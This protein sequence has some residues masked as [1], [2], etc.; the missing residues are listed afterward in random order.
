MEAGTPGPA[1]PVLPR[2]ARLAQWCFGTAAALALTVLG[3]W[4]A[5]RPQAFTFGATF[6]AMAPTTALAIT[7][8][9]AL[10]SAV[11]R[12]PGPQRRAVLVRALLGFVVAVGVL[13]LA[14]P[15]RLEVLVDSWLGG[16]DVSAARPF[17][18]R[19]SRYTAALLALIAVAAWLSLR[20]TALASRAA[21]R[22]GGAATLI[23]LLI[24]EGYLLGGAPLYGGH[25]MPIALLTTVAL[26]LLGSGVVLSTP[27]VPA[28]ESAFDR[29]FGVPAGFGIV[30]G[31]TALLVAGG[32][33]AWWEAQRRSHDAQTR[34]ALTAV[35]RG[36]ASQID[37]WL[38][39]HLS[40]GRA[41]EAIRWSRSVLGTPLDA[42]VVQWLQAIVA[43]EGYAEG[44]I[45][46]PAGVVLASVGALD[47]R[48]A[49]EFLQHTTRSS[50]QGAVT[51]TDIHRHGERV[52]LEL[53]TPLRTIDDTLPSAWLFLS[54]DAQ[55]TL[56][57]QL[58]DLPDIASTLAI[59]VWRADGD[60]ATIIN[61]PRPGD[62]TALRF[63][64]PLREPTAM[65]SV[66]VLRG[67]TAVPFGRD[68]HDREVAVE[69]ATVRLLP[70]LLAAKIDRNELLA[71]A[72]SSAVRGLLLS[73]GLVIAVAAAA[74]AFLSRRELE[75]ATRELEL[76]DARERS[77]ADLA[78]SERRYA[79]AIQATT[80]GLWEWQ[81]ALDALY[82]SAR[83]CE[84]VGLPR[85]ESPATMSALQARIHPS[86]A[87]RVTAEL[88]AH[89][90]TGAAYD[91]AYRIRHADGSWRWVRDRAE[92]ERD[93]SERALRVTGA[94]TDITAQRQLEQ[95]MQRTDRVLRVRSACNVA[96]VH[97]TDEQ[98]LL[99]STCEIAVREGGFRMAWVGY[100]V[101]AP[102][103]P[104]RVMASS[105]AV[106][107]YLTRAEVS[108]D[109]EDPR[110]QGPTGRCIRSGE[111][112]VA[113]DLA[114]DA[115]SSVWRDAA[116]EHGF[117][118]SLSIPLLVHG[119]VIGALMLYADESFAFDAAEQA[120]LSEVGSDIAFGIAA[121]RD[122]VAVAAQQ[123]QLTLFREVIER[124]TDAIFIA[125]AAT[126]RFVD[127]NAM[128]ARS[129]G[130]TPDELL[131]LNV[132][133]IVEPMSTPQGYAAMVS[134]LRANGPTVAAS[135]HRRKDAA[136]IPVEVARTLLTV[137]GRELIL[138]IARDVS[139]RIALQEQLIQSQKLEGLGRL[140]GGIAHDFNNM[141]T[142]INATADLALSA[143]PTSDDRRADFEEIRGAGQRAAALTAQLLSFSR[144]QVMHREVLD[145]SAVTE[146]FGNLLRRVIGEDVLLEVRSPATPVWINADP[147]HLEQILMNLAVNAR[148]ALPRGG[149]VVVDTAVV[150]LNEAFTLRHPT[151]TPGPH[152]RLQVRDAG[153][154][155]TDDVK[156]RI[157]EPFFTTKPAGRG[158][159]LGLATV[160]GLVKQMGGSI[161]ITSAPGEGTTVDIYFPLIEAPA[162]RAATVD[163]PQA[164]RGHE[165]ILVVEDESSIR[166]VA[167]RVLERAGYTVLTASDATEALDTLAQSGGTVHLLLSDVVMPGMPGT[168]LAARVRERYPAIRILLTSGYSQ[169]LLE[170]RAAGASPFDLLSKPYSMDELTATVRRV[171]DGPAPSAPVNTPTPR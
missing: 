28:R 44:A 122:Q 99:E 31:V 128:A 17:G 97:A 86:D 72:T 58:R 62:T 105:G 143:L 103:F 16:G 2:A 88:R 84:I 152:A 147:G 10:G 59:V 132:Y 141:L 89:V 155:M 135:V 70:W 137:N 159:G 114:R 13:G 80:D 162:E 15:L 120:L 110:G 109:A 107:D 39:G 92:S 27:P 138:G 95:A 12:R 32:S 133:D 82:C 8:L 5:G 20:D 78:D 64:V 151:T 43:S 21:R 45:V 144:R 127:F 81:P 125:D 77:L 60:S 57:D 112:Q 74:A 36:K 42:S 79:R 49:S 157:F 139:E 66:R 22:C 48:H 130:Y 83:W 166:L 67:E 121:K 96:L 136:P 30:V 142:V 124:S 40:T 106:G 26:V 153:T 7:A 54:I 156:A 123:S 164:L 119:R 168:E 61:D 129:L 6:V 90:E 47:V 115:R 35:A 33:A 126:G 1:V 102:G 73:L 169:E 53:W 37:E 63:R 118:A 160:Y 46:S 94:M 75:A 167:R 11:A 9:A 161:W 19:M 148:D 165:T 25:A 24:L 4:I 149:T 140:A 38:N 101:D 14:E 51:L 87:A 55:A 154:G 3:G 117:A 171:L 163:R 71:P 76:V 104:V 100:A 158:T 170:Q 50:A 91:Q 93:A 116:R 98:S 145:V 52:R 65:T 41:T 18:G 68:H 150:D 29:R 146:R 113:Q 69:Y 56:F 34:E 111:L 23:A 131:A 85:A 108:W 134:A